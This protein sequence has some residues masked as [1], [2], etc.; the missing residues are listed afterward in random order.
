MPRAE[1]MQI[2]RETYGLG[3]EWIGDLVRDLGFA[4][5][6]DEA[7][8]VLARRQRA[9]QYNLQGRMEVSDDAIQKN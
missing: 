9:H 1:A 5:L 6:S 8:E 4:A 3:R 2:I 7:L